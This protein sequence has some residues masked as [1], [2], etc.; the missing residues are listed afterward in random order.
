ML[1]EADQMTLQRQMFFLGIVQ[2][3]SVK[4]N[5]VHT[6]VDAILLN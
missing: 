2:Y 4:E 3:S 5:G 1:A 6:L